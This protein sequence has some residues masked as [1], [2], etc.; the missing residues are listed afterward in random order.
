MEVCVMAKRKGLSVA[1]EPPL[2]LPKCTLTATSLVFDESASE[3]DWREAMGRLASV[4]GASQW[5]IGDGLNHGESQYGDIA[6][7]A[8]ELG[9]GY[10]SVANAKSVAAKFEVYRRRETLPFSFHAAVSSLEEGDQDELLDWAETPGEDGE[11]PTRKQL[12]EKVRERKPPKE[13]PFDGEAAGHR[14]RD[15]LRSELDKWP[16]SQRREAAHWIRQIIE[17]E[18]GL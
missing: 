18:Y 10:Q 16:D 1:G 15:W 17:K 9:K 12:R 8:A 14:L 3:K 2:T 7:T 6:D 13:R 11:L 5:W 4:A